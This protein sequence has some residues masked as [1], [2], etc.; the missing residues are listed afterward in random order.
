MRKTESGTTLIEF[1]HQD[2]LLG[3]VTLELEV[4]WAL[5][6]GFPASRAEPAEGPEGESRAVPLPR[7][8]AS[9]NSQ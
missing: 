1:D 8:A 2:D 7:G 3:P 4:H 9:T 6:P 5:T